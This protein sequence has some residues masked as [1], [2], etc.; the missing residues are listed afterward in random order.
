MAITP[1]L[2]SHKNKPDSSIFHI[3]R[4]KFHIQLSVHTRRYGLF[5]SVIFRSHIFAVNLQRLNMK[6][7]M[8]IFTKMLT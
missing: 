3:L 1:L 2:N 7:H 8:S 6:P 5:L 4:L